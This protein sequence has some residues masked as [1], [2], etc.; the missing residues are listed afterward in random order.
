[1]ATKSILKN[2]DIRSTDQAKRFVKALER[3]E[4]RKSQE[5]IIDKKV[6]SP[7]ADEIKKMFGK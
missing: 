5:V 6:S 1:M 3:A 4:T 7:T 2:I